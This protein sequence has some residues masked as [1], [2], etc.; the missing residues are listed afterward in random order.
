MR[1]SV[2]VLV[3]C[4]VLFAAPAWAGGAFSLFGT[5]GEV[6]GSNSSFGF[7]SRI[8]VGGESV[9]VDLTGTWFPSRSA[10]AFDDELQ[11]IP[12]DLGLRLLFAPGRETRPYVGAGVTYMMVDLSDRE[13]DDPTGYYLLAG[14][15]LEAG[16]KF[17]FFLEAIYRN[18]DATVDEGGPSEFE[19]TIGGIAGSFGVFWSF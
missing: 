4:L 2:L 3:G 14:L 11:V 9:M 17:G 18:A 6:T 19:E 13:V 10:G 7:G 8:S 15:N 1:K 5:Y 12:F 16:E